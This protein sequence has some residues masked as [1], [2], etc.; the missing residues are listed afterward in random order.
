MNMAWYDGLTP[1][2]IK[3]RQE[4]MERDLRALQK[5]RNKD[6]TN[7]YQKNKDRVRKATTTVSL[8]RIRAKVKKDKYK[9]AK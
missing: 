3:D 2:E 7:K 1:K 9:K 5:I 4:Q 6:N 8:K